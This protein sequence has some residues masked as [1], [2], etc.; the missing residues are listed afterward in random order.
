MGFNQL[1]FLL[2]G[3]IPL[4]VLIYYFFRKKYVEKQISSTLFW[5]EVMKETKASPYL[6]HLQRNALFYL[7]ILGLIILVFALLQPYWKTKSIAGD[8]IIWVVDTSATML[9]EKDGQT[10][11][12]GHQKEM[13]D[14]T[15]KLGGKA[16]TI[17]TTG[18]EPQ[19]ILR[20][21]TNTKTIQNAVKS[22]EVT[23]ANEEFPKTLD[24]LQTFISKKSAVIYL[25]TDAIERD[26]L[27]L[28]LSDIKWIVI[29]APDDL[30]NISL[31]RFGATKVDGQL[32]A[33]A[34]VK[35]DTSKEQQVTVTISNDTGKTLVNK[36]ITIPANEE[37]RV[38]FDKLTDQTVLTAKLKVNDNYKVDNEMTILVQQNMTKILVD[39]GLQQLVQK[40][41]QAMDFPVSIVPSLQLEDS[42]DDAIIVTNQTKLLEQKKQPVLLIGRD[43]K[44]AKKISGEVETENSNLFA[45]APIK[46]VYVNELYPAFKEYKTVATIGDEPFI[47]ISPVGHIV[48]LADIQMTDWPLHPS[49]PL[50]LWSAKENLASSGSDIGTFSPNERRTIS[51][52]EKDRE[53]MGYEIYTQDGEYIRSFENGSSFIAPTKPGLYMIKSGNE[54]KRFAVTLQQQEKVI[55]QGT[56]FEYGETADKKATNFVQQSL[57]PLFLFFII[58]LLLAEWEV[59]RRYGF[60]H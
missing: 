11:F 45:Y 21:E 23:Y 15:N 57:V 40:A 55:V 35:N 30:Q 31:Q 26:Q 1:P 46:D 27:P 25:F 20:N 5:D 54:E 41:F 10:I 53:T 58:V 4:T 42:K 32:K 43:D 17:M 51:L 50:F 16:V 3:I 59:Q 39:Q 29:G 37:E 60:T 13:L 49:F 48:V 8:Q 2:T 28:E 34:Q 18:P 36:K 14:L 56:S 33:I 47:Q 52:A 19:V 24:F 22:L 38:L 44:K 9:A 12:E 6:Q 7:Q